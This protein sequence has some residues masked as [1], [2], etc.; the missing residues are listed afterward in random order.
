MTQRTRKNKTPSG[1]TPVSEEEANMAANK[2][3]TL[4]DVID[5]MKASLNELEVKL[6]KK[7]DE[8][9][10]KID[11]KCKTTE[12]KLD[13]IESNTSDL[14]DRVTQLEQEV[15]SKNKTIQDLVSRVDSLEDER[16]SQNILI[17]GLP[18][19]TNGNLR[20][21]LDDLFQ[22]LELSYDS[23]WID[24]AYRIG[25]KSEQST[26]PRAVKLRFPFMRC[27]SE[28]YRN[29]FKLKK[30]QKYQKVY[31]VEDHPTKILEQLKEMRAINAFAKSQEID[32]KMKGTKLV[33]DSKAYSYAELKDL[34]YDLS[35]ERA[36]TIEVEDGVAFQSRHSIL[37]NHHPC[38]IRDG[39]KVYNSSEQMY[40][41]TR[42]I[43][44]EEGGVAKQIMRESNAGKIM[45]L[46][47]LVKESKEWKA[48]EVPTMAVILKKKFDQNPQ[49]KDKLCKI[50]GNFYEA[51][52]HPVYGCG[53]SLAQS[54]S[55]KKKNITSGNKL[56]EELGKLRDSYITNTK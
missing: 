49:L 29:S 46:G 12:A 24:T 11:Q 14:S 34:P 42:A 55:I 17:E 32:S 16:K 3:L 30:N 25:T 48:K 31:L 26:R 21:S 41:Y 6:E 50:T 44:N 43:E 40:H 19:E 45:R 33:I 23:E 7:I 35:I 10:E 4:Q 5:Q 28:L 47:K 18:E 9:L 27:K 51:T 8:N 53:F 20:K 1:S 54:K 38:T 39:D 36:K 13:K 15:D 22:Y 2:D 56:G 37:S 52:L